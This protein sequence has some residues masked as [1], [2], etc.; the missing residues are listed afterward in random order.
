MSF[1]HVQDVSLRF[2]K[3][4]NRPNSLKESVIQYLL[5]FG[6]PSYQMQDF[7]VLRD[8]GFEL[9]DGDRLGII[10]VNGAGK[11]SLLKVITG[12]YQPTQ[13]HVAVAG[14]ISSLI[15]LGAGFDPELTGRENIYL[16]CLISGFSKREIQ[17]KEASIIEFSELKDFIDSPIKYYS[18]GMALRLGFS[19]A[20]TINPEILIFDELFAAGDMCFVEKALERIND[21]VRNAHIFVTVSHDNAQVR[22]LCNKVLYLKD[23]RVEYF[24]NDV[25]Y[26]IAQYIKDSAMGAMS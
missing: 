9:Q 2:I 18:S 26:G 11:S 5:N 6:K 25:E 10:G 16:N 8:V 21:M 24:G 17:K 7:W 19:I 14:R 12:I 15:E 13:G 22:S 4:L 23:R 1:I 20:T 3:H